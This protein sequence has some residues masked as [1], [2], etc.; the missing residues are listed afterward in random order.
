[1]LSSSILVVTKSW[2]FF[3]VGQFSQTIVLGSSAARVK[4]EDNF[5]LKQNTQ[6]LG[7]MEVKREHSV[8]E[9]YIVRSTDF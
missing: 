5:V 2:I 4:V 6:D 9:M 7:E 1:M 3:F 8:V